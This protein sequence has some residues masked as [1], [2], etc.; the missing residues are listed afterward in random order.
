MANIFSNIKER[1]LEIAVNKGISKELFFKNIGMTYGNFKGKAKE[2]PLNSDTIANILTNFPDISP[3]WLL[4][5]KGSMLRDAQGT[6]SLRASEAIP[7]TQAQNPCP[8]LLAQVAELKAEKA[9][10]HSIITSQ[11]A[12]IAHQQEQISFFLQ[13]NKELEDTLSDYKD[14]MEKHFE[15]SQVTK[16]IK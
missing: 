5:G 7:T 11:Q 3:E 15:K 8:E 4:T 10:L 16:K 14:L 6:P 2:T 1:C 13:H 9:Q 12:T